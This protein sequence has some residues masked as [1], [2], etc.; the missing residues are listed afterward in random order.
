MDPVV[1]G[2]C[3]V[4]TPLYLDPVVVGV[5]HNDLLFHAQAEAVRGVELALARPQRTELAADLHRIQL[6]IGTTNS[7][8]WVANSPPYLYLDPDP[9]IFTWKSRYRDRDFTV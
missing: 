4:W 7:S 2:S 5:C 1:N 8:T 9:N 3:Y 6:N